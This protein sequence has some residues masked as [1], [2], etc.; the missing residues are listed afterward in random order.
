MKEV[1]KLKPS[2][3]LGTIEGPE[4]LDGTKLQVM[5]FLVRAD[6]ACNIRKS[7]AILVLGTPLWVRDVS[8]IKTVTMPGCEPVA[9]VQV[10]AWTT[11]PCADGEVDVEKESEIRCE[12]KDAVLER[13]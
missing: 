4:I 9:A 1:E 7:E 13:R 10:T 5:L 3:I 2:D 8:E 12:A 11:N 6:R